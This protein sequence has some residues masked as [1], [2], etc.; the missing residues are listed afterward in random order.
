MSISPFIV[1]WL[2]VYGIAFAFSGG[3]ILWASR[4][5][6]IW[7]VWEFAVMMLPF[8]LWVLLIT[9]N[10]AGKSLS[11][12]LVEP[13]LCGLIASLQPGFRLFIMHITK[14]DD[15]KMSLWGVAIACFGSIA[16][17]LFTPT[18]VE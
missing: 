9:N 6:V 3:V 5:K 7:Q 1:V 8:L 11:N 15:S 12:A 17:Y 18:L 10:R 14:Q 4:G 2:L 13:F 16:V